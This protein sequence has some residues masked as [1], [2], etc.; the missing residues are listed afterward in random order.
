MLESDA[1]TCNIIIHRQAQD[2]S[3]GVLL[4]CTLQRDAKFL[5][6]L[7]RVLVQ[8]AAAVVVEVPRM[9]IDHRCV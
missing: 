7:T 4:A 2:S 5:A 9:Q 8:S 3:L 1:N 6:L